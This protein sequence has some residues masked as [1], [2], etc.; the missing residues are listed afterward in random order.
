[1][2]V[3]IQ[4]SVASYQSL[5]QVVQGSPNTIYSITFDASRRLGNGAC[6]SQCSTSATL[7]VFCNDAS[8][9]VLSFVPSTSWQ[10]YTTSSCLTDATGKATVKFR[11]GEVNID[12]TPYIDNIYINMGNQYHYMY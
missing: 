7:Q 9:A 12:R 3:G 6:A 11:N 8:T 2:F 1:M 5:Q 10:S 4:G